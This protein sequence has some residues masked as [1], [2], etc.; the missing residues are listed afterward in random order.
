MKILQYALVFIQFAGI[1]LMIFTGENYPESNV[2]VILVAISVVLAFW[3]YLSMKKYTFSVMPA[4][5]VKA[6]LC[7]S[8]PY[9]LI[10]HPMYTAVLLFLTGLL[11]N[12]FSYLRLIILLIVLVDLLVKISIE[13][14]ILTEKYPEYLS[15]KMK[16]R[17]ILPYIF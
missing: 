11:I 4:A 16:T 3:A 13:E 10:R 6:Q 17:K 9:S 1:F 14:R 12:T 2:S 5:R 15:Y 8:G 7:T